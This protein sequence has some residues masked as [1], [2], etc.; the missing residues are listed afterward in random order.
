MKKRTESRT[1]RCLRLWKTAS[2]VFKKARF[3]ASTTKKPSLTFEPPLL[4]STA[5]A[6][7]EIA[8]IGAWKA[9]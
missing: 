8:S 2:P 9:S 3:Q 4:P 7:I 6:K 5:E 1:K